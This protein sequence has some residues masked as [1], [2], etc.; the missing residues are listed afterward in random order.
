MFDSDSKSDQC[1]RREAKTAIFHFRDI[2]KVS[3]FLML[4]HKKPA[5]LK[6]AHMGATRKWAYEEDAQVELVKSSAINFA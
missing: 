6:W 2:A 1:I 4:T 3:L 5:S